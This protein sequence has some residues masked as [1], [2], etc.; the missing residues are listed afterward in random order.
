MVDHVRE[1]LARRRLGLDPRDE[2]AARRPH[3]LDPHVGEALVEGVD[4]LLLHL[5]E[6]GG[7]EDKLAFFLRRLD[8]FRRSEG[9]VLREG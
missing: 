1:E 9:I 4:D 3:H 7:V 5:G 8:Q 6:V 2:L